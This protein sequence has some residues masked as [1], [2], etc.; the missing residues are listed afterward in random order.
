MSGSFSALVPDRITGEL[1][2]NLKNIQRDEGFQPAS[3]S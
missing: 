3:A 1:A 2:G